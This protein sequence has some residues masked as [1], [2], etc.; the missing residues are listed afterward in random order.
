MR[1]TLLPV[2]LRALV[3]W[4]ALSACGPTLP[5][6]DA[7]RAALRAGAAPAADPTLSP[8]HLVPLRTADEGKSYGVEPGGGTRLLVAGV[9][10]IK[11]ASGGVESAS[12]ALPA[13]PATTVEIPE[14]LGGGFLFAIGP[15][16]YRAA[17]WLAPL[18][19]LY[20]APVSP[21]QLFIGLDRA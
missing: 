1:A 12:D 5:A 9:R 14:R 6:E 18:E 10:A 11:L 8:A 3:W 19:M 16:V 7:S 17:N 20:A 21:T 4:I 15:T 13:P 2:R